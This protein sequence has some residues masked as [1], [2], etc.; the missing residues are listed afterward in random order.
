M[1][2]LMQNISHAAFPE[3][4]FASSASSVSQTISRALKAGQLRKLLT[5]VY[6]SNFVDA[7]EMIVRRN[8]YQIL[9]YLYPEAVI[10]HRSALEG[11][12]SNEGTLVLTF[13]YTKTVLL[14]GITIRLV[15]GP[16]PL[17]GDTV[18]MGQLYLA[19][20]ARAFLENLKASRARKGFHNTLPLE[21]VEKRL[22][23]LCRVYGAEALNAL[24]DESKLLAQPL[25][26]EKEHKKLCKMIGGLLGSQR[27]R[28][29][30]DQ[31]ASRA[32]GVPYDPLRVELFSR[33]YH[34]LKHHAFEKFKGHEEDT[35]ILRYLAFFEAYFSN[36]IEGTRFEVEEARAIVFDHKVIPNRADDSHDVLATYQILS[37]RSEMN[38]LPKDVEHFVALLKHRHGVMMAGRTDKN[39][40]EFKDEVNRAG[41]TVFVNPEDVVGTLEKGFE[42]YVQLDDAMARAIMMMFIVTE[43]HPFVD[44]NGRLARV[45]MNAELSSK[46]ECRIIVPTVLRE[47]YLLALRKLSREGVSDLYVT[48]LKKAQAFTSVIDFSDYDRA[49][50]MMKICNA[51]AESDEARL[52]IPKF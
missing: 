25:G 31:A 19:S 34:V 52:V 6:T 8:L 49:V 26:C 1:V 24:R 37:S 9:G 10:S 40:G 36:Y 21:S 5:R 3:L 33:L 43:V 22:D 39:P 50:D 2:R 46:N 51:F 44:G 16:G 13:K 42:L 12:M 11:A 4:V 45:M 14:P 28:F 20:R 38:T 18:F 30:S 48:F 23:K 41:N 27:V 35:S 7:D 47:D 15:K 32:L 17:Q 29:K